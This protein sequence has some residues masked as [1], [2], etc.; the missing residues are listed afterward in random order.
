MTETIQLI[1]MT[2]AIQL[3]FVFVSFTQGIHNSSIQVYYTKQDF[4]ASKGFFSKFLSTP[5]LK[6]IY[7]TDLCA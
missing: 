6:Y 5:S 4:G 1:F 2:E 3:I 7:A